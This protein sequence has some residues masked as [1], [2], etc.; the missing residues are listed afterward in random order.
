MVRTRAIL[1]RAHCE[2]ACRKSTRGD[3]KMLFI[4]VLVFYIRSPPIVFALCLHSSSIPKIPFRKTQNTQM[5]CNGS[6]HDVATG[7]TTNSH[8]F[9]RRKKSDGGRSNALSTI[10]ETDVSSVKSLEKS[11][12]QNVDD[13]KPAMADVKDIIVNTE[14]EEV[15]FG[16][17]G[18]E[19]EYGKLV[20]RD[21][22]DR[23]FSSRKD[24]EQVAAIIGE[25]NEFYSPRFEPVHGL[26]DGGDEKVYD[27]IETDSQSENSLI[28]ESDDKRKKQ[29]E[30]K[31]ENEG[32]V[33][34]EP[35][36]VVAAKLESNIANQQN[37][38]VDEITEDKKRA[39]SRVEIEEGMMSRTH[40][41]A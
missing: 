19:H 32:V 10:P 27:A 13:E 4:P 39:Y 14:K 36:L 17:A 11:E 28:D 12:T 21:S 25:A 24:E 6:K 2:G 35:I 40:E 7:N 15:A 1:A 31:G 20:S 22:P 3:R 9:L 30:E 18:D 23:Y 34:K 29:G 33:L 37:A 26:I 16:K 38:C 41:G 5:G 8:R